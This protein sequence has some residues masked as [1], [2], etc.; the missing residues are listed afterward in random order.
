MSDDIDVSDGESIGSTIVMGVNREDS[1]FQD[2]VVDE[3]LSAEVA[4]GH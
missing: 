4:E 1:I 3:N 2:L